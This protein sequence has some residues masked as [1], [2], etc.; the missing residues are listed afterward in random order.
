MNHHTLH[1]L[2]K[3][4]GRRVRPHLQALDQLHA[5]QRGPT[6]SVT[7]YALIAGLVYLALEGKPI[8]IRVLQ[9]ELANARNRDLRLL[10]LPSRPSYRQLRYR[11]DTIE[12]ACE[13]APNRETAVQELLDILVP[14]SAGNPNGTQTWAVDTHLFE[15]WVNQSRT[16]SS[17]PDA[18]WRAMATHKHKNHPV[19]GYQLT[20]AVRADGTETCDRI[21]ISTA[22]AN[23]APLGADTIKQ[24]A[25]HGYP[26]TRVLAD[27]GFSQQPQAFLDPIRNLGIHVTYDLKDNDLGVSGSYKG[28]LV[29]DGW[30]HSPA[31]PK[32]LHVIKKPSSGASARE[33]AKFR[34]LIARRAQYAFLPHATPNPASARAASPAYRNKLRCRT[35][36]NTA[37]AS[38]PTCRIPHPAG[39]ACGLRTVTFNASSAPRT[40]QWPTWGSDAWIDTYRKRS[41]VERFFGHLQSDHGA[42]FRKGR[43]RLRRLTKVAIAT[44]ACVIATNISLLETAAKQ[45]L[46]KAVAAVKA[47]APAGRRTRSYTT[48][49]RHSAKSP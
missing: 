10:G 19:L 40:Y 44:A 38:V 34:K 31:T 32:H 39:Q 22:S 16:T 46:S 11:L 3:R 21:R 41:A 4:W 7:S 28:A 14:H 25:T 6:T 1:K 29:I 9:R 43:Y 20:A 15:A 18:T 30:L 49:R 37:P 35:L 12:R 26:I 13:N 36:G 42:G 17:D 45:A 48:P 8:H 24:L 2:D 33:W 47:A 27:R 23:D 5:G